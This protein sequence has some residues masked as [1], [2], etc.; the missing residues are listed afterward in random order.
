MRKNAGQMWCQ[1][2][3][4][5]NVHD[6]PSDA[7]AR[8]VPYGIYDVSKNC[9]SVYVG[10][11][12]DTPEFAVAAIARWWEEEGQLN[13][14]QANQLL[15]LANAGESLGYRTR[16]FKLYLQE[17]VSDRYG[18]T[19]RVCHYPTGCSKWNPIEHRLFSQMSLNWAG[20]PLRTLETMLNFLRGTTTS[21][22][23]TVRAALL[24][25][26]F[27]KGQT[28][29]EDQMKH[30]YI[31]QAAVCPQWNYTLRPRVASLSSS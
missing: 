8:A 6:F 15:I 3:D 7:L 5:V 9:G 30:L 21:T 19:V 23:L 1:H 28:V 31:E 13:Y 27:E 12:A 11:S 18:L 10:I 2:A 14:P 20:K 17:R 24:E 26:T 25:G 29:S 16:S 22:G 4:E